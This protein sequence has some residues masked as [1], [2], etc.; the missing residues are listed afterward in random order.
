MKTYLM[1]LACVCAVGLVLLLIPAVQHTAVRGD[2]WIQ[3]VRRLADDTWR[4]MRARPAETRKDMAQLLRQFAALLDSGRSEGQAWADLRKTWQLRSPEHP[5]TG[6]CTQVAAAE[7]AGS[8][9]AEGIRRWLAAEPAHQ[10]SELGRLLSRLVGVCALSE[11]TGAP[12]SDL[13]EQLAIS[14]DDAAELAAAV[15]T[16][17]AG[18]K[19]TQLILMLLPLG[20]L[21]LGQVMGAAPVAMLFGGFLGLACLVSGALLLAA[22]GLWSHRMISRV[23]RRV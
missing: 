6:L 12:L 17:T 11:Q 18:P 22:G 10:S 3:R 23:M 9:T 15:H 5:L 8:G 14:V 1:V 7:A 13:V 4:D 20:G 21:V 2:S 16:S 19:L